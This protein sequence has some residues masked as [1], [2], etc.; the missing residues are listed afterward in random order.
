MGHDIR[1][2][3]RL[4]IKDR[5]FTL[6]AAGALALCIGAGTT[7]FA[8]VN[9]LTRGLPVD[10]PDRVVRIE[11]RDA[12]GRP[13]RVSAREVDAWRRAAALS[14][15][16]AFRGAAMTVG[17]EGRA[18]ASF[19]GAYL[20]AG[21]FRVLRE[22]PVLGRDFS[23]EDDTAGAPP[24][25]ILGSRV[26]RERYAAD[27]SII[28]R[29]VLINDRPATVIGVMPKGFR[30]PMVADVWQPLVSLAGFDARGGERTLDVFGRLTAAATIP[31]AQ[32]ELQAATARLAREYPDTVA[33]AG[34]A[35]TPFVDSRHVAGFFAGLMGAVGLVLLIGCANVANLL[36]ARVAHRT[37]DNVIRLSLGATRLRLFRQL[38]AE[39]AL[40][41]VVAGALGL[42][43]AMLAVR[44]IAS[45]LAGINFPYWQ[46]WT[47]DGRVVAFGVA[48]SIASVLVFGLAPALQLSR[49]RTAGAINESRRTSGGAS[50]RRWTSVLLAAELAISLVLLAGAGLMM[51]S[52]AALYRA[53][54]VLNA[55]NVV[56]VHLNLPAERY[57]EPARRRAFREQ[58]EARLA[59]NGTIAGIATASSIPFIGS[60]RMALTIEGEAAAPNDRAAVSYVEAAPAYFQTLGLSLLRG[61]G[62]RDSLDAA[63]RETAIVN[64][65]FAA[66]YFPDQDP[67]GKRIRLTRVGA[68]GSAA[69]SWLTIVGTS[70]SVRHQ[71]TFN[72]HDLDPVVYVP[73][74]PD[75][76]TMWLLAKAVPGHAAAPAVRDAMF[77]VDPELAVGAIVAVDTL[78]QQ[79]RWPNRIFAG[80]FAMFA[81][82]SVVL[83]AI[84]LYAVT[85]YA[86][87]QRT[88]EVGVRV[89]L[90]A[91]PLE[92]VWLFVRRAIA[93]LAVGLGAGLAGAIAIG[94][95]LQAFL[96]QTAP[97]D[98]TTL[99]A[100]ATLLIAVTITACI[101]PA[102]RAARLDP[103]I[104]LRHE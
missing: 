80:I 3:A 101:V 92:V 63:D 87:T 2:A 28:G 72:L 58:L 30:F 4:L 104:A 62:F 6:A 35:V 57:A 60:P 23:V 31:Q 11:A 18:P 93:P 91:R 27:P 99:T 47:M 64:E 25:V 54:Q 26:W 65:R 8:L 81:W 34:V 102:R 45:D 103:L 88:R 69:P 66:M 83:A 48:A 78:R 82:I 100:V 94:R 22:T 24:V 14:G 29:I 15:I 17:D 7:A 10:A 41:G 33:D 84:G 97:A 36:L 55:S 16:A 38:L 9:A 1:I 90:G 40:L 39:S 86:I 95:L 13:L 53:D 46:R 59:A 98:A 77:A 51:R 70:Q 76:Q 89:A 96:M 43:F 52:F 85:S 21:A 19:S 49:V 5:W 61:Q 20:A 73:R 71:Q 44:L 37:N 12:A 79:S 68:P 74:A 56:T 67:I 42:G 50:A 75:S 32:S